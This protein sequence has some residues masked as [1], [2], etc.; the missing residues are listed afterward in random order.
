[1]R[2]KSIK[3]HFSFNKQERN[4]IFFLLFIILALQGFFYVGSRYFYAS[5]EPQIEVDT[6]LQKKIDQLK[7]A[8]A[9]RDSMEVYDFNP[10]FITD[11]KGYVLGM[12]PE[13][14]DRLHA[15]RANNAYVNS[16]REF[17]EVTLISDS[18]LQAMA[19]YFKFPEWTQSPRR[20][21]FKN[22]GATSNNEELAYAAG[23]KEEVS[24]VGLVLK[25][26]NNATA[27]DLKLVSGV[28]VVLS[29]RIVKFRDRL[30][31]FVK[32]EQLAHVY[33][34]EGEVIQRIW[35]HFTIENVPE[36]VKININEAPASELVGLVYFNYDLAYRI[37]AHRDKNGAF[38][39]FDQLLSIED[40]PSEKLDIIQLY[41]QL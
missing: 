36:I 37:V 9:K 15:F 38:T 28:G 30:G 33:G 39:S 35:E 34:L 29:S 32:E 7:I 6:E 1:M 27:A 25:D 40:F 13:E 16:A 8:S 10:N 5:L 31:G 3:S 26:L 17:Q 24:S 12:S 14:I 18:L 19:P 4:G 22:T 20:S 11:Y 41:L 21:N 2:K 23:I